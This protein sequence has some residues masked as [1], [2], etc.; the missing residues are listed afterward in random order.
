MSDSV[1]HLISEKGLGV[2]EKGLGVRSKVES[3]EKTCFHH[4]TGLDS[5][6]PST[7]DLP[8][9]LLCGSSDAVR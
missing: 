5:P 8:P 6:S 3:A 2:S 1:G 9:R 7:F 4:V